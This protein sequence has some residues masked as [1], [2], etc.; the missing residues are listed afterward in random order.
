[1]NPIQ[2]FQKR[3]AAA[4]LTPEQVASYIEANG[5]EAKLASPTPADFFAAVIA[6]ANVEKTAESLAY[7]E[8]FLRQAADRGLPVEAAVQVT[9]SAL[10]ATFPAIKVEKQAAA[11]EVDQEKV[12]YFEGM[13]EKGASFG[14]DQQQTAQLIQ[15]FAA[16]GGGIPG[17]AGAIGPRAARFIAGA[18]GVKD[19]SGAGSI[20]QRLAGAVPG[21][22][23][24]LV[25]G[26]KK[27]LPIAA[28]A[29]VAGATGYGAAGGFSGGGGL[30]EKLQDW[31]TANPELAMGLS[32]AA[33]GGGVGGLSG[34]PGEE[35][36][37]DPSASE[38]HV[39]RN[40]LL[41]ALA[42][43]GAGAGAGHF[44]PDMFKRLA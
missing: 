23:N 1:M 3:A 35:D 7:T 19:L 38:S 18:N 10:A 28:G 44:A 11:S 34:L 32:G 27:V 14:L 29:G 24:A 20:W 40:A 2:E 41:G 33:I 39:G 17:M 15:K 43:G 30:I 25:D 5:L 9:K 22:K 42:G 16:G 4:G 6:E 31:M 36:P 26:A 12:A 8:G 37:N 21:A 13:F